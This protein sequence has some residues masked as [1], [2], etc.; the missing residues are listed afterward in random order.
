MQ[1][2]AQSTDVRWRLRIPRRDQTMQTNELLY[3]PLAPAFFLTLIAAFVILVIFVEIRVLRYAYMQLGVSSRTALLLLFASLIGSYINI[4]VG[5]IPDQAPVANQLIQFFGMQYQV[6]GAV[7]ASSTIIA[8]NVGGAIIPVFMSLYLLNHYDLWLKGIVATA[9][10]AAI[11]YSLASPV[12]GLG[13]AVPIFVPVLATAVVAFV[14]D[15]KQIASL[16]YVAGSLGTLIGAD[17]MNIDKIP[18]LGVPVASIGGAGT[19]DGIFL[20]S[21][22]AVLLGSVAAPRAA[23][24]VGR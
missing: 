19:F 20:T 11:C 8:V 5:E 18:G 16:A 21:I 17:L 13:V 23:A 22:L 12:Q 1:I 14:L 3:L 9:V 2:N 24:N 6:P 15:R 10:V 7:G 4:P